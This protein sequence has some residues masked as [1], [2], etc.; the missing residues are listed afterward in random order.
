MKHTL[1]NKPKNI[2]DLFANWQ[3]DGIRDHELDWGQPQGKE[4]S[5][6]DE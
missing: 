3:D 5:W 4:L 2:H 1:D 6:H